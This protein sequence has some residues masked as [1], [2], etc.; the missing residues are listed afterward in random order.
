MQC[1]KL[2][3][4]VGGSEIKAAHRNQKVEG[5]D[6]TDPIASAAKCIGASAHSG[7]NRCAAAATD[8]K[9]HLLTSFAH[10]VYVF[11]NKK[12]THVKMAS[13]FKDATDFLDASN[14]A[15]APIGR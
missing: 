1:L 7:P 9:P 6:L 11:R 8:L 2:G 15:I 13:N 10:P 5:R 3:P 14:A 12:W 4:K